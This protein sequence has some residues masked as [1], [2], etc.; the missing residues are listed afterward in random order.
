MAP[1]ANEENDRGQ[2]W[3]RNLSSTRLMILSHSAAI[4]S[5]H[6]HCSIRSERP[7][8]TYFSQGHGRETSHQTQRLV[9][10]NQDKGI[11]GIQ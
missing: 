8:R 11:A 3:K 5:T 1:V 10:K 6:T 9:N 2:S 4:I 7:P